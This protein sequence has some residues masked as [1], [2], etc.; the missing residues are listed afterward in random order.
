MDPF[1]P[2]FKTLFGPSPKWEPKMV[3]RDALEHGYSLTKWSTEIFPRLSLIFR[4]DYFLLAVGF[5]LPNK[6]FIAAI[7]SM[8]LPT[9]HTLS[10]EKSP[11]QPIFSSFM[12]HLT[13]SYVVLSNELDFVLSKSSPMFPGISIM[14]SNKTGT[15]HKSTSCINCKSILF[16]VK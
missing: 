13:T 11:S 7:F 5:I 10:M 15:R 3:I 6:L 2:I 12:D 4:L 9:Q 14:M 1:W 8:A 16:A